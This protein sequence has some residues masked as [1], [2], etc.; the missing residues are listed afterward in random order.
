MVDVI[1]DPKHPR[2]VQEAGRSMAR[3]WYNA[4]LVLATAGAYVF[5]L[6]PVMPMALVTAS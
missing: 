6:A 3:N 1:Y 4:T 5:A 2:R